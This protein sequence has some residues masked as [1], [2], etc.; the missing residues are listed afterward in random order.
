M[1]GAMEIRQ[2]VVAFGA[3]QV[4]RETLEAAAEL[5]AMLH[6]EVRALLVEESWLEQVAE[7][8]V[9]AEVYLGSR[10][11]QA[12]DRDRLRLEL[13]ARAEQT[14]RAVRQ[15]AE[16][17]GVRISFE[18]TQGDVSAVLER[19]GGTGILTTIVASGRPAFPSTERSRLAMIGVL[20][21]SHGFTLVHR[22]GRIDRLPILVYYDGSAAARRA[23][24]IVGI[25]RPG[26]REQVRVLLP[27][28]SV[29]ASMHLVAEVEAWSREHGARVVMQ[30]LASSSERDLERTLLQLRRS[31]IVLPSSATVLRA[32]GAGSVLDSASAVLVVH[33]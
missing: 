23:L 25:L 19:A 4:P 32:G 5:A 30:Q 20:Q 7:H 26:R 17:R 27:P 18:V 14:R 11:V 15:L 3:S 9:T 1:R 33:E 13:R 31:L 16:R 21:R 22:E 6:V 10:T 24:E 2:V 29:D 12:W 8:P 28:A